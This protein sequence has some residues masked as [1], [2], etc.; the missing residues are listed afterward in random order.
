MFF[1]LKIRR[2]TRSTRTDTLF[3]YTTL[4]RS[5]ILVDHVQPAPDGQLVRL[6]Q[7]DRIGS[8]EADDLRRRLD[9]QPGQVGPRPGMGIAAAEPHPV[10][11]DAKFMRK[12]EHLLFV[13]VGGGVDAEGGNVAHAGQPGKARAG[14][15]APAPDAARTAMLALA[16]EGQ[17]RARRTEG[18]RVGY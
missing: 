1:F 10:A 11:A 16:A 5:D 3:P 7:G 9:R 8:E 13:G 6:G 15:P 2:P 12:L 14:P 17:S 4:F 18:R